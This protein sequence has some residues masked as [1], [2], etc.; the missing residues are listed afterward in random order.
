MPIYNSVVATSLPAFV[1]VYGAKTNN[2]RGAGRTNTGN[3]KFPA[4]GEAHLELTGKVADN[5]TWGNAV[6]DLR[7][8]EQSVEGVDTLVLEVVMSYSKKTPLTRSWARN[9]REPK[10]SKILVGWPVA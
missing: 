4:Y 8:L 10:L 7:I 2:F 5:R 3:L 6:A 9:L 1:G